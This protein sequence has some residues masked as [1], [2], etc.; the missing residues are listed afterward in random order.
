VASSEH[1]IGDIYGRPDLFA[2]IFGGMG[3][4]MSLGALMNSRLSSKYGARRTIRWLLIIYTAVAGLLLL[5]TLR[6]G[7]P[8]GMLLFFIAI[9]LLMAINLAVEPNSSALALDPMGSMAGMASSVYGTCFFFIGAFLGSVISE[10]MT[11]GV[12]A[13]VVSFFVIGL[14]TILLVFSDRRP[15]IT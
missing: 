10:L 4:V 2:W 13:L 3:L 8:P 9:T 12:L 6:F 14:A 5:F 1:I 11:N 7:D 15:L